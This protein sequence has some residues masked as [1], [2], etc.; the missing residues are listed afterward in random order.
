MK[1]IVDEAL[2]RLQ[3]DAAVTIICSPAEIERQGIKHLP[4]LLIDGR[5]VVEGRVP[6]IFTMPRLIQ[7][8]IER[9]SV[10]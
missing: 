6:S 1:P 10:E 8:A 3:V 4:A 5:V 9:M 7:T 2:K